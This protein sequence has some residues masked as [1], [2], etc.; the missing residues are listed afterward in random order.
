MELT[1]EDSRDGLGSEIGGYRLDEVVGRGGMGVVYKATQLSLDRVVAVKLITRE[2]ASDLQFRARFSRETRSAAAIEHPSIV[3]VYEA[4]EANGVLFLAMRYVDGTDLQTLIES[5]GALPHERA[6]RIVAQ[7]SAALDAAHVHGLIH[8][9]VKPGNVLVDSQD[10]AYLTDFG[11]AKYG[12]DSERQLTKPGQAIGSMDYM[13]PEQIQGEATDPRTDVYALGCVLFQA[14]T[15]QP[16][17]SDRE[18]MRVLWAH[19]REASPSPSEL[20]SELPVGFDEVVATALAKEPDDRY[21]TAGAL[22]RAAL[23]VAQGAPPPQRIPSAAPALG[24]AA[25][26]LTSLSQLPEPWSATAAATPPSSSATGALPKGS[27]PAPSEP[28]EAP[29]SDPIEALVPSRYEPVRFRLD[30]RFRYVHQPLDDESDAIPLLG[31]TAVADALVERIRYSSGGSFLVTGFRGVG[32]TTVI[33]H[34][35]ARLAASSNGAPAVLPVFLNVAR[36]RSTDELLFEVIRRLF[37]ALVDARVLPTLAPDVQRRL[38][39]AYTRTSL[40]FKESRGTAVEH[41]RSL[42]LSAAGPLLETLSPKLELSRKTTDSLATEASFLAYSDADVEHDFLRI[43]SLFRRVGEGEERPRGWWR[44]LLGRPPEIEPPPPPWEGK[45]VVVIDELDKLTAREDGMECIETLLTGLKNLLTTRGVHFLFVAGPDLHD[46]SLRQSHRGNSVYDSVFGWQLYVPCLWD[47]TGRLLEAV[48]DENLA[49]SAQL[50]SLHDYLRFKARGVPRLLLMELN[51]FVEWASGHPYLTLRAPD[52]ARIEFYA[53]LQRILDDFLAEGASARPFS[54]AIDEDRWRVGAYYVTDRILR[55]MGGTFTV[56][57]LVAVEGRL[58]VDPLLILSP[59]KVE[60]LVEHL[61]RNEVLERT[62]GGALDETYFGDVPGAQV[63][64]YRV[65]ENVG[66][67]LSSFARV[68]ERERADLATEDG[69]H[70]P[71]SGQPWANV[72]LGSVVACRYEIREEIDREGMGRVYRAHDLPMNR[73]VAVKIL[74]V[75]TLWADERMRNRFARKAEL[76]V[77]V[78]HPNIVSTYDVF[79]DDDGRP[80]IVMQFV[81]GTSLRQLLKQAGM[82]PT[83]AVT[84]ARSLLDA[85]TYL[86]GKGL[87]RL[88]LKPSSILLDADLRPVILDVGLA[89]HVNGSDEEALT[90]TGVMVGTPAYAAPEQIGGGQVDIRADLYSVA[91]IM[92]ELITGQPVRR[93]SDLADMLRIVMEEDVDVSQV[94]VSPE[95]R[96]VLRRGLKKAPSER[97]D[98]PAEMRDALLAVPEAQGVTE[99]R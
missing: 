99:D 63:P 69:S 9:D 14:L 12:L 25:P 61:V 52:L 39:L 36:P 5:E 92:C 77:Q 43:V 32:K 80:G 53:G 46:V 1:P 79:T 6:A 37:E 44:R 98:H 19:L 55:T 13:A 26:A 38:I 97:Y 3:P 57:D 62:R 83:D 82:P 29:I 86:D 2:L 23:A 70:P 33:A 11:L 89:K 96:A 68:N 42:G 50:A 21:P 67:K 73:Q 71:P 15:G 48:I 72:E 76:A 58:S 16:P 56:D 60:H 87:A 45:V 93:G 88:D 54:V 78:E 84:V 74:D 59:S 28:S 47:A 24:P 18:G 41:A 95:L 91:L 64:V 7:I 4:G 81:E 75:S 27:A 90:R 66:V 17:F 8:R 31:N 34:A 49:H 30:A 10:H 65:A 22:G 40:S 20:V 94:P 35:L 85:L 51:S